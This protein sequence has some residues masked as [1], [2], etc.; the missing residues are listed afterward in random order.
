MDNQPIA[1]IDSG[2]GG[3][4]IAQAIWQQLPCQSTLYLADHEFFPYGNQ[5]TITINRRLIAIFK[6]L[7]KKNCKTVVVACNTITA[8]SIKFLRDL[9]PLP[10]IGI[11]PAIKPAIQ[12]NLKENILVWVT[13]K[14]IASFSF[15]SLCKQ[16]DQR[17]Q[18]KSLALPNL[19]YEIETKSKST[20]KLI[21]K[22]L[23]SKN[24]QPY[25]ALVL[26]C[27]HYILIKD[28]IKKLLPP[29]VIIIEPSQAV[30][31]QTEKVLIKKRLVSANLPAKKIFYTTGNPVAVTKKAS[32]LLASRIIFKACSL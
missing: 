28:I 18:I 5:T 30:A 15:Q 25:S 4:A 27:T 13:P 31:V 26:G 16:L 11:E 9:F 1:I 22:N 3:L 21:I 29:H 10:I 23:I 8:N 6:F 19:A 17:G 32:A 14:T 20:I 12:A 2:L 7:L 24:P